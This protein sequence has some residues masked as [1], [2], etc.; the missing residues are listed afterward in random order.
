[1]RKLSR[2]RFIKKVGIFLA[3]GTLAGLVAR[4]WPIRGKRHPLSAAEQALL[5]RYVDLLIPADET[6]GALDLDVHRQIMEHTVAHPPFLKVTKE[7]G[8]WLDHEARRLDAKDFV[9]LTPQHQIRLI[10]RSEGSKVGTVQRR[11]FSQL[12]QI[13]FQYYYG[14]SRS[15][16]RLGFRGPPQPLGHYDYQLPPKMGRS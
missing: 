6:P 12:R 2:R 10:E 7:G 5:T 8:K 13:S 16:G 4:Y 1:M 11:L 14:D 15:W 9:S 3:G